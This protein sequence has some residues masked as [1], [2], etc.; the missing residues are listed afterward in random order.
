MPDL[1]WKELISSLS[2][3]CTF[4]DP[5]SD[6]EIAAA[7]K[8]LGLSLPPSLRVLLKET[9]GVNGRYCD[10]LVWSA[11]TIASENLAFRKDFR[12]LYMPFD[13]L[14]FFGDAGNGDQFA[15]P[16]L[17]NTAEVQRLDIFIWDHETD[18]RKW[19]ARSLQDHFRRQLED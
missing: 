9:N 11:A 14:L 18:C 5:A 3:D 17:N 16:L 2:G 7:E 15:Y 4:A 13:G 10:A 8:S 6:D 1:K 19:V 12:D